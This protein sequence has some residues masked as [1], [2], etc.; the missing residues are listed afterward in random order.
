MFF[1]TRRETASVRTELTQRHS[2]EKRM[3]LEELA[4]L[5]DT[6]FRLAGENWEREK[7]QLLDKVS[8][9]GTTVVLTV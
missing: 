9:D 8:A 4:G 1:P 2:E 7:R 5:K 6:A 3:A